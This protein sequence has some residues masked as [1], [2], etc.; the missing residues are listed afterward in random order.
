L[1]PSKANAPLP[2]PT[3]A[4]TDNNILFP[5]TYNHGAYRGATAV[6]GLLTKLAMMDLD[7][8]AVRD[9]FAFP[10]YLR[11]PVI[12]PDA[13]RVAAAGWNNGRAQI[14]L[15]NVNV[16]Q[17]QNISN[18]E[19]RDRTPV[20]SPD[21]QRIAFVT[22][23]HGHW[24]IY[25]M[26]LDGGNQRRLTTSSGADKSPAWSPD[27][28]RLAFISNREGGFDVF[29]MHADGSNQRML[30]PRNGNEYEPVWSLDGK[31]I[32]CTVQRRWN[33]CIQICAPD[34]TDPQNVAMG[35]LTGLWSI[36]WSP[37]GQTLAG[38]FSHLGNAGIVVVHR[39]ASVSIGQEDWKGEKI[40]KLVD[41]APVSTHHRDWY[42]T[43]TGTPRHVVR[44]FSGVSYSPDGSKLVYCS[45]ATEDGSFR[46][47][48]IASGP[49]KSADGKATIVEPTEL[50]NTRTAW[51]VM[52]KWAGEK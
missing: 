7:G 24:D 49:V 34:G 18:N 9:V 40:T 42:H 15:I 14:Y 2:E 25:T 10:G 47:F 6:G 11:E 31:H 38:A 8:G 21:G 1:P 51:P 36:S 48:T 28:R 20:F 19:F 17:A 16:G 30:V 13:K 26:A 39:A 46:L 33:R 44:L 23:R 35:N 22:D 37:D 41:I 5:R 12:S 52:T 27:G 43:G 45:N 32:A 3:A 29:T 4:A 50:P